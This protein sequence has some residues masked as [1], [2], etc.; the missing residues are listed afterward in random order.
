MEMEIKNV[1]LGDPW[2]SGDGTVVVPVITKGK[3]GRNYVLIEEVK[4]RM[5]IKDS[6]SISKVE[7]KNRTDGPVFIRSGTM[8]EGK[9]TQSRMPTASIIIMP[10]ETP[11]IIDVNCIHASHHI[12]AGSSF[13]VGGSA[14]MRVLSA[15]M[16]TAREH[17]QH[18]TWGAVSTYSCSLNSGAQN[19]Q[20]FRAVGGG[21][22]DNL[23]DATDRFKEDVDKLIS[24][25]PI[26]AANQVG[27]IVLDM[28]GIVGMEM[29]DSP[30]SWH[31]VCKDVARRYAEKITKKLTETWF[32]LD[33]EKMTKLID[34]F[35]QQVRDA[36]KNKV[37]EDGP[38][39]T[40]TFQA[41]DYVGEVVRMGDTMIY[42]VAVRKSKEEPRNY[43]T[44]GTPYATFT[45]N[46]PWT[47]GNISVSSLSSSNP[48]WEA[49]AAKV[50]PKELS[51]LDAI[52]NGFNR[53]DALIGKTHVSPNTL[54]KRLKG[55]ETS[56]LIERVPV[57]DG[58]RATISY[59]LT[60]S[61][62]KTL[63][64]D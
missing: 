60:G 10:K 58:N 1:I 6:G 2:S 13:R 63:F 43:R 62:K 11:V 29:F 64:R 59:S 30:E 8:L 5:D 46:I 47:T 33:Q 38:A 40:F 28:E 37:H 24:G 56:G 42:M 45:T 48:T 18:A 57:L 41:A 49:P 34:G 55:F 17:R 4:D 20:N 52:G 54:S 14:P 35:M 51:T 61:G 50:S 9:G 12:S 36:R 32:K 23:I 25:M 22:T 16:S 27:M 53:W 26:Q 7:I 19:S 31:A 15:S 39:A 21:T 3:R 44:T